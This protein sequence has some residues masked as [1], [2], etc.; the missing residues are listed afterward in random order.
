MVRK[1]LKAIN[2]LTAS[3]K[4]YQLTELLHCYK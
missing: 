2:N 3:V 4:V 1:I